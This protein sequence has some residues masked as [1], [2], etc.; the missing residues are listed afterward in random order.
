MHTIVCSLLTIV[1]TASRSKCDRTL[2]IDAQIWR[3]PKITVDEDDKND[4]TA[5]AGVFFVQMRDEANRRRRKAYGCLA[6]ASA[7]HAY[8]KKRHRTAWSKTGSYNVDHIHRTMGHSHR[9]YNRSFS[10]YTANTE[11]DWTCDWLSGKILQQKYSACWLHYAPVWHY[12]YGNRQTY[13]CTS[14]VL[15]FMIASLDGLL[16]FRCTCP[17]AK[18][19]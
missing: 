17:L 6:V 18:L 10:S 7:M 9:I 1:L 12:L 5:I 13:K 3:T 4:E 16:P 15:S 8:A 2:G 11:H 19:W 14:D